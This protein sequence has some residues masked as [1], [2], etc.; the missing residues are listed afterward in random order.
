MRWLEEMALKTADLDADLLLWPDTPLL[1]LQGRIRERVGAGDRDVSNPASRPA[2]IIKALRAVKP[3]SV[4]DIC[5]G[6]ALVL[7]AVK[8]ALNVPCYGVDLSLGIPGQAEATAAGVELYRVALQALVE[9]IPPVP[10]SVT[11]MLNTYRGW[12]YAG[13]RA[14]EVELPEKVTAWLANS[15]IRS[16]LTVTPWQFEHLSETNYVQALGPGEGDKSRLVMVTW[17]Y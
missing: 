11:M 16:V 2:R 13:L 6:D 10:F 14:N 17:W 9:H 15:S 1:N 12:E 5:C 3:V 4:L 7:K 8:D